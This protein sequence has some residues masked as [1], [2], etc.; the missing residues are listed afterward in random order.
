MGLDKVLVPSAQKKHKSL[1]ILI[2]KIFLM[3]LLQSIYQLIILPSIFYFN[4]SFYFL[5][6]SSSYNLILSIFLLT[7]GLLLSWRSFNCKSSYGVGFTQYFSNYLHLYSKSSNR[8]ILESNTL[9]SSR[10]DFT[11]A[12]E[13]LTKLTIWASEKLRRSSRSSR[14]DV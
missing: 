8:A 4:W 6:I 1:H 3:F 14:Q 2:Q 9:L 10:P 5:A 12:F 13:L 11:L 7:Y